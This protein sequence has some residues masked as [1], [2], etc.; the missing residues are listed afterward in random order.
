MVEAQL[1]EDV[2][3]CCTR[4]LR[5]YFHCVSSRH[6]PSPLKHQNKMLVLIVQCLS[7]TSC[8]DDIGRVQWHHAFGPS[9]R[10]T[11]TRPLTRRAR[12]KVAHRDGVLCYQQSVFLCDP[13]PRS[14]Q[15][16]PVRLAVRLRR[17]RFE[18][19]VEKFAFGDRTTPTRA[20]PRASTR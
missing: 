16:P 13:S 18:A 17:S 15:S 5:M 1:I 4:F 10:S 11:A 14:L 12:W 20:H 19:F 6:W 9:I 7:P 2:F 3:V 8:G